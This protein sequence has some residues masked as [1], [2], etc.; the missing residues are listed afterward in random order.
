MGVTDNIQTYQEGLVEESDTH[1]EFVLNAPIEKV[2]QSA[3]AI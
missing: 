2:E 3:Q 1:E